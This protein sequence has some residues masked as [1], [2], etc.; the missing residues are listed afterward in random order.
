MDHTADNCCSA[1]W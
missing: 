1:V